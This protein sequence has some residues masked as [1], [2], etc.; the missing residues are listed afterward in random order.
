MRR[1]YPVIQGLVAGVLVC[2]TAILP[3]E[4]AFAESSPATPATP[5]SSTI[6]VTSCSNQICTSSLTHN[7]GSV[8]EG[9][10]AAYGVQVTNGYSSAEP[11]SVALSGSTSITITGNNCGTSIASGASCEIVFTYKAPNDVESDS[12]NITLASASNT[13]NNGPTGRVYG[14]SAAATASAIYV[15]T[16]KHNFGSVD[17]NTPQFFGWAVHNGS[18]SPQ[19]V[20]FAITGSKGFS[21]F[22]NGCPATLAAGQSCDVD[23]LYAPTTATSDSATASLTAGIPVY[24]TNT[25]TSGSQLTLLGTPTG[26]VDL[27]KAIKHIVVIYDENISYDHYFGTYPNATNQDGTTFTAAPGTPSSNNYVSNPSLLTSNP[28]FENASTNGANGETNPY[29]LSYAQGAATAS[30][31]HSYGPEQEAQDNGSMDLYPKYVG[32]A[33]SSSYPNSSGS[34]ATPWLN[35]GYYDGNVTT[36]VWNYAQ[37]YAMSDASFGTDFGPSTNG[38]INVISG[39]TNGVGSKTGSSNLIA[40]GQGGYTL[41]GDD[42]PYGDTCS[43]KTG[44]T[45]QMT[46][47]NI[48]DLLNTAGLTWGAFMGGFD[49]NIVNSNGTTGCLRSTIG[50]SQAATGSAAYGDYIQHHAW[51]QYYA[52]TANYL[53]TRPASIAVIGTAADTATGPNSTTV[54][55]HQYDSK[56]FFAALAA[57]NLPAVSFLKAPAYQDA[58][59]GYS[60][61]LDEQAWI[62]GVINTLQQTQFWPNTAVFIAYDDSDGWYDHVYQSALNGS[63][64]TQDFLNGSGKCGASGTTPVLSGPNSNGAPVQGRCGLGPRL[65]LMVISPWAKA[66]YIDHTVVNQTSITRFIEDHMLAGARIG[67]GSWDAQSG[68][69]D[70]MFDTTHGSAP[71]VAPVLINSTTGAVE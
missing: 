5:V 12:S 59:A 67:G 53:H 13:F 40:D 19:A 37:H 22:L 66:N 27:S 36:A 48:G 50:K 28:N 47:K 32:T 46:G 3:A 70:N 20:S 35:L 41:Y 2:T 63:F 61:P 57:G 62:S 51:F 23:F 4:S 64:T 1:T 34:N 21:I 58:H 31:N 69:L 29:R 55:N 8:P 11:F 14:S 45:V 9:S 24:V 43:T 42:D 7:F 52:S 18:S 60:N 39:Q 17:V 10:T 49:L 16:V 6:T 68:V 65:P 38:A 25:T 30:Q 54:A 26:T 15:S 56:D 33:D 71:N 44:T